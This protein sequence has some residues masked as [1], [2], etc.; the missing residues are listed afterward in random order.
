MRTLCVVTV[1]LL[2]AALS[3][4]V[5]A[6]PK[7]TTS[8]SSAPA[9]GCSVK[10]K[11]ARVDVVFLRSPHDP[12][13]SPVA[14]DDGALFPGL[15]EGQTP[16]EGDRRT[17][18]KLLVVQVE[19]TNAGHEKCVYHSL[20]GSDAKC[21]SMVVLHDDAKHVY[22]LANFGD[23]DVVGG[24]K[25][26]KTLNPGESLTDVLVFEIPPKSAKG[27]RLLVPKDNVGRKERVDA[28]P[29]APER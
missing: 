28:L 14:A 24:V 9:V 23:M 10:V 20:A 26:A 15:R 13:A 2:V 29:I 27:L 8:P 16:N 6:D 7:A 22:A 17:D 25:G 1:A 21:P 11:S 18:E 19:V 5:R 12:T 4:S 3:E